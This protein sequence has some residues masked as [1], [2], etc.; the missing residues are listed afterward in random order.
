[1]TQYAYNSLDHEVN[2]TFT[3]GASQQPMRD[4][5]GVRRS[6]TRKMMSRGQ[7]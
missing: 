7:R 5:A 3:Q 1:M 6:A 4:R 2:A